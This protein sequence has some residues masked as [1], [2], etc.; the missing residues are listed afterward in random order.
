[1]TAEEI[2]VLIF[3]AFV[4]AGRRAPGFPRPFSA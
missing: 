1:M 4:K 2:A 3:S